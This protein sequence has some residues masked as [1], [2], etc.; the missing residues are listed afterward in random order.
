[1]AKKR[2][3]PV[4]EVAPDDEVDLRAQKKQQWLFLIFVFGAV[5]GLMT[6]LA[7]SLEALIG[8]IG[9]IATW[10]AIL[11]WT[12]ND[13]RQR[14][15]TLWRYFAPMMIL[16]PG[17]LIILPIYFVRTRGWL[18]GLRAVLFAAGL[19]LLYVVTVVACILAGES[20][21]GG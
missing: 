21:R 6:G 2:K 19:L 3:Q 14:D 20:I 9:A 12:K 15:F 17:P 7:P 1:M 8:L 10:V 13:A 16:C 11:E 18:F 4:P 5:E